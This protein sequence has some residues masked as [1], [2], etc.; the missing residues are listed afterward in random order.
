MFHNLKADII[1]YKT[2]TDFELEFNLCG[3]CRM[4]LLSDKTEDKKSFVHSLARAVSR[5]NVIIIAGPLFGEEGSIKT[6]ADAINT[7]T[8]PAD[9][10]TY[11]ISTE[12]EIEII[13]DSV[14][15]VTNEGYFGGCIIESGPQTMILLTDNKS[16]RKTIMQTLI[17]PYITELYTNSD[18]CTQKIISQAVVEPE[19]TEESEI[20]EE[21]TEE[22][23]E[24]II[25]ENTETEEET[26]QSET[27]EPQENTLQNQ[28]EIQI[29]TTPDDETEDVLDDDQGTIDLFFE[30]SKPNRRNSG[31][32]NDRYVLDYD[33]EDDSDYK[34]KKSSKN[35]L[36]ICILVI[37]IVLLLVLAVLCYSIFFVPAQSGI[38]PVDN[39]KEIYN[40]MFS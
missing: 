26:A 27:I 25:T 1:Y 16:V 22:L 36:S 39:L 17:H 3:C 13:K 34:L 31:L 19:Q 40:I 38:S 4:R 15:L 2:A 5:S 30:P 28:L 11:N 23:P 8:E 20:T 35:V 12:Q 14:P 32:Y 33:D 21:V 7:T 24:E 10:K 37:S 18:N 9:N 29:D 6:V